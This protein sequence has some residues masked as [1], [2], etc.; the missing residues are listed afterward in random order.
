MAVA[1]TTID[2]PYNPLED[3]NGWYNWDMRHGYSTCSLLA[4]IAPAPSDT[5]PDAYNNAL[6]EQAIDRIVKLFPK[7][8]K[9]SKDDTVDDYSEVD[10]NVE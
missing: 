8:Y 1:L 3:F 4:R 7:T 5:L 6:K 9:K 10:V 2:N